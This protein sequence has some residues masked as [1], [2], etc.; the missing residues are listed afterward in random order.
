[1]SYSDEYIMLD[2]EQKL[3][4][5]QSAGLTIRFDAKTLARI[6]VLAAEKGMGPTTMMRMWI[7]ERLRE[8]EKN[9]S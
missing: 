1:M 9:Q 2:A 8:M 6:R 5:N 7:L 4:K 3:Q